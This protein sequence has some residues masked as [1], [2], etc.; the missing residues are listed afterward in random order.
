MWRALRRH[1]PT[2]MLLAALVA[3]A[4]LSWWFGWHRLLTLDMLVEQRMWLRQQVADRPAAVFGLYVCVYVAATV[5]SLPAAALLTVRGGFLFGWL[6]GATAAMTGATIGATLVFLIARSAF[7]R[8]LRSRL[9][10]R[11]AQF[12]MGFET[13]AFTY[14]L[15]LRIAP[16]L[17][18]FL[19]NILPAMFDVRLRTYVGATMLG[20]IPG[21]LAY[22]WLGV[23]LDSVIVAAA[24]AG[25]DIA[26]R[27]IVTREI[28]AAFAALAAV[29]ALPALVRRLRQVRQAHNPKEP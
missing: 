24:E 20:I 29:A 9:R 19:M 10:G 4:L 11:V 21:A 25:R 18:F 15:A 5:L 26:M 14:L 23:G 3:A 16:V 12:A 28:L 27:D 1:A 13:D 8:Y 6:P 17:P 22:S 7:G 2:G